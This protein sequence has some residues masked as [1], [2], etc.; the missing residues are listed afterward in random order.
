MPSRRARPPAA[1]FS[2]IAAGQLLTSCTA[3]TPG[4]DASPN[5]T[6]VAVEELRRTVTAYIEDAAL[7]AVRAVIVVADDRTLVEEYYDSAAEDYHN[8]FSVTKSVVSTLVGVAVDEG[9][10]H[11]EQTLAELL[12]AYAGGMSPEVGATTL[13]QLLTMSG[14]FPDTW[15]GTPDEVFEQPDWVGSFLQSAVGPPGQAFA[16]SDPGTHLIGAIL[17]QATGRPVL[18]YAREKLFAPLAIDTEPA[19]EPLAVASNFAAYEAADFAWPVDP[20]GIHLPWGHLKLRPRDMVN[21]GSLHLNGGRWDGEEVVSEV[22]VQEATKAQV[23]AEGA[24][25]HYGYLWWVAMADDSPAYFAWGY[26]GQLIEVVPDRD[27]VVAIVSEVE[28]YGTVGHSLLT[29]LVDS[30]I[31]PAIDR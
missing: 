10:L 30:V 20:Q 28:N 21:F 11:L 4:S 7:D 18:Q 16:Y 14:G 29:Y 17:V 5:H 22:W 15:S 27:L 8:V 12:P 31:A 25:D 9:L 6:S 23:P 13:E 19:A 26:G 1:L 2:V 24:A 3:A